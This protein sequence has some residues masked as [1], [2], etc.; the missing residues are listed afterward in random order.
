MKNDLLLNNYPAN[1][2]TKYFEDHKK[3][4][5]Y[6]LQSVSRKELMDLNEIFVLP[7]IK[8]FTKE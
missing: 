7:H 6:Q 5:E 1:F 2:I 4:I 8:F 3:R